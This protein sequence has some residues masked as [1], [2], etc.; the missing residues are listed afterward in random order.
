MPIPFV[1]EGPIN[2]KASVDGR[3]VVKT[4]RVLNE[5]GF[6]EP[7]PSRGG[8]EFTPVTEQG[9]FDGLKEFQQASGLTPSGEITPGDKT[10]RGLRAALGEAKGTRGGATS[11]GVEESV[12]AGGTNSAFDLGNVAKQLVAN[13][14]L[15]D[16]DVGFGAQFKNAIRAFQ[17]DVG[18]KP[19]GLIKPGGETAELLADAAL[20]EQIAQAKLPASP[21]PA[22]ATPLLSASP[23]TTMLWRRQ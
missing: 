20:G 16:A 8:G 21:T 13:G 22:Q 11:Q 7:A 17:A 14:H 6:F 18:L 10:A 9:L 2:P 15:P 5:L 1:L 23:Q 4:K 12:G 19:D 3:D